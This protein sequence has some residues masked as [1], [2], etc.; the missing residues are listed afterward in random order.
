M[1][2]SQ[3]ILSL[4]LKDAFEVS[5]V[6]RDTSD[7]VCS[8][9][10]LYEEHKDQSECAV[11]ISE[12]EYQ[13][14]FASETSSKNCLYLCLASADA[15]L[16]PLEGCSTMRVTAEASAAR[17]LNE[18]QQIFSLFATWES[19]LKEVLYNDGSFW[20]ISDCTEAV[21]YDPYSVQDKDF[22]YVSYSSLSAERGLVD[23]Y[24]NTHNSYPLDYVTSLM[25]NKQ[26][27]ENR[28]KPEPYIRQNSLGEVIDKN[29]FSEGRYIGRIILQRDAFEDDTF[30]YY[31]AIIKTLS[32]Y[33]EKLFERH[34]G[35][36]RNLSSINDL[37]GFIADWF[38]GKSVS[39]TALNQLISDLNWTHND[40][41]QLIQFRPTPRR[42]NEMNTKYLITE[43][44][45]IWG[46]GIAFEY[47][48]KLLMLENESSLDPES[49]NTLFQSLA[50]FL[51]D[52]LLAASV[53]RAFVD[54]RSVRTA[55]EQ[56]EIAFAYG[57][58]LMPTYW[59]YYFD[60]IAM[61]YMLDQ[62]TSSF[63][64]K[65]ICS[66]EVLKLK[67][68]DDEKKTELCKTLKTYL[69]CEYNAVATA[70]EL[71]IH[72]TSFLNRLSRIKEITNIRFE[73]FEEVVYLHLSL[74]L[75]ESETEAHSDTS[76]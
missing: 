12:E 17:V 2:L 35:F 69:A 30:N 63:D 32:Y 46:N 43:M 59:C 48:E 76:S 5:F 33:I 53:S 50:P 40:T 51:R 11:I 60:N 9:P 62:C 65:D 20:D 6:H 72:R 44:T 19:S 66:K 47:G 58:K 73:S 4:R 49:K 26:Y 55:L 56:T 61:H 18:L 70:K 15:E 52:N 54:L 68:Y 29:L 23:E 42:E 57:E 25:S 28:G 10:A 27:L 71:C 38:V 13:A 1:R 3:D 7:L 24:V 41:F 36:A 64:V 22:E 67:A 45:H 14:L 16:A 31:C 75:L 37:K 8:I 39:N 21:L 74:A 34:K